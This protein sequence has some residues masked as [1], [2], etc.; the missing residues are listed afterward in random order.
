MKCKPWIR[1]FQPGKFQRF[2]SQF[3]LHGLRALDRQTFFLRPINFQLQIQNRAARRINFHYRDR[4]VGIWAENLSVQIQTLSW[5]PINFHYRYRF[6]A[7]NE[8]IFCNHFGYNGTQRV[9]GLKTIN[10][11]TQ[12][13]KIKLSIRSEIFNREWFS[14]RRPSLVAEETRPK[15]EIFKREWKLQA[16]NE[17]FKREWFSWWT[18]RFFFFFCSGEGKGESEALGNGGEFY[19]K[20]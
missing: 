20:S 13:W 19:W 10:V 1:H 7:R 11:E 2:S 6:W 17:H 5:I 9:A 15:I 16:E 3:A 12:Y 8:L 18:F 14:V 4:S